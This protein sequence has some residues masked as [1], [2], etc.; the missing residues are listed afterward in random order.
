MAKVSEMGN[1]LYVGVHDSGKTTSLY[2]DV[3]AARIKRRPVVVIDS[4]TEH[5]DRSLYHRLLRDRADDCVGLEF[6]RMVQ[7][8]TQRL[9]EAMSKAGV[10]KI[11]MVDVSFYLE[12][13]HRLTD[14]KEKTTIRR[15]YQEET[16]EV[17]EV[18]LAMM[19][20]G[21]W[22]NV[23]VAMDEIEF[24]ARISS[25][26]RAIAEKGGEVHAALHPPLVVNELSSEFEYVVLESKEERRDDEGI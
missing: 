16:G 2:Q 14:P 12:E 1:R 8:P 22:R 18:V 17:L 26:A 7:C 15:R 5:L 10:G 13:G 25:Y 19:E 9:V 6:P 21:C 24:T 23:L 4:A 11:V 3:L 20:R